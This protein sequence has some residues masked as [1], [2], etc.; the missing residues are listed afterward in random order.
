MSRSLSDS[1][2]DFVAEVLVRLMP[3]CTQEGRSDCRFLEDIL[4]DGAGLRG[5][6]QDCYQ[7]CAWRLGKL[8]K[9]VSSEG[10]DS[11]TKYKMLCLTEPC[12]EAKEGVV[13][14]VTCGTNLS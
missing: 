2:T 11:L 10:S 5:F 4:V 7:K 3:L 9:D 6:A 14:A 8:E 1:I 12:F 13:G